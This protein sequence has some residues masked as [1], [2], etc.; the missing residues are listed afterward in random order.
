MGSG[1]MPSAWG[2]SW[3]NA[4]GVAWGTLVTFPQYLEPV[5]QTWQIT[6]QVQR[7]SHSMLHLTQA[8]RAARRRGW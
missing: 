7:A 3:G 1:L 5:E 2:A 4:W 8:L 6:E